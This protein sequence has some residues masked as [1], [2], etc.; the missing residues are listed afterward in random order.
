M[1]AFGV[2]RHAPE[3]IL[4]PMQNC[5]RTDQRPVRLMH[6][7]VAAAAVA[8]A[9]VVAVTTVVAMAT[10]MATARA[11]ATAGAAL[12]AARIGEGVGVR[13]RGLGCEGWCA[14]M[15]GCSGVLKARKFAVAPPRLRSSPQILPRLACKGD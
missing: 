1:P 7:M 8:V 6:A 3:W 12:E 2:N 15:G 4:L 14:G 9:A 13:V 5:H 10:A 11:T